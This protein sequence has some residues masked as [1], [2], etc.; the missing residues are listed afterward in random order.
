M[1]LLQL[2]SELD[3]L[4]EYP[5]LDALKQRLLLVARRLR[6]YFLGLCDATKTLLQG[7]IEAKDI[8]APL[9]CIRTNV[10][11]FQQKPFFLTDHTTRSQPDLV[12]LV[13]LLVEV[14][15]H[16]SKVVPILVDDNIHYRLCKMM[17]SKVYAQYNLAFFLNRCPVLYGVWHPYK[18]PVIVCYRRFFPLFVFLTQGIP[19]LGTEVYPRPKLI[20]MDRVM[21]ALLVWFV[22]VSRPWSALRRPP[23]MHDL[24]CL[25][26]NGPPLP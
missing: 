23:V 21:A 7:P 9:D 10:R 3:I 4:P 13:H 20:Y 25:K 15:Q 11:S 18:Y 6:D 17:Y 5:K 12:I 2:R 14:Q 16:S 19:P 26:D 1:A 22:H 8:R 24:I